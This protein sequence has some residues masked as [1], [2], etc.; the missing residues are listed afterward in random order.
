MIDLKHGDCLELMKQIPDESVDMILCD[1]PYGITANK[2][3]VIIPF[4]ELWEQYRRI[5]KQRGCIALFGKEPFSSE[6]RISNKKMYRYDWVWNKVNGGNPLLAKKM[7]MNVTENISIFYKKLPMY[8]PI[9]ET[10]DPKNLRNRKKHVAFGDNY[11]SGMIDTSKSD[12]PGT[13]KYPKNII[14]IDC[15][16]GELNHKAKRFH[17]TQKPILLL[18]YLIKTYTNENMTVLD[19]CMGSGSTGV[20]CVNTD[21]NF[22]GMELDEHY[23]EIAKERIDEAKHRKEVEQ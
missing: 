19:N 3:D 10:K 22:I 13:K 12:I 1:L 18:E 16:S 2:W 15:W 9:K 6:L 11:A 17:P 21:R 14:N 23:F 5:I 20:A 4:K 8:N 7:P